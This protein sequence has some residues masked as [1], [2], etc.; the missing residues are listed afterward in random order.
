MNCYSKKF[1][2]SKKG[3]F[4]TFIDMTYVI[5]LEDSKERHKSVISQLKKY[6]LTKKV[7][8]VFNKGFKKCKKELCFDNICKKV[9]I[10]IKD[11]I[12]AY[13]YILKDAQKNNYNNILILEDDFI[14]SERILEQKIINDLEEKVNSYKNK[15]LLL[16]LG[17]IPYLSYE[18]A[19]NS[20]F[21]RILISVGTHAIIYNKNSINKI[22]QELSLTDYDL[23]INMKFI[24]E[25]IMYKIPLIY[26]IF[27]DTEN[28]KNW[29]KDDNFLI[30][31]SNSIALNYNN[32][33]INLFNLDK[34]EEP[35]TSKMYKYH[36]IIFFSILLILLVSIY[37]LFLS[38][39]YAIKKIMNPKNLKLNKLNKIKKIIK[40]KK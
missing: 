28:K 22:L 13:Q 39:N 4:D 7:S 8:I 11:I 15:N 10:S 40:S 3:I 18:E 27:P 25:Q 26:Q 35:G 14:I 29:G 30:N 21:K 19:T 9:N 37:L 17:C 32:Q 1:I 34:I 5:T 31:F 12:H 24:T 38:L 6:E 33:I 36:N 23:V 20:N 16:K 2:I